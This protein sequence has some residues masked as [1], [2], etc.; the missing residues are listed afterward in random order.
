MRKGVRLINCAAR[1]HL[2]RSG[3][4]RRPEERPAW[5][6]WR[7]TSSRRA[8]HQQPAVRHAQRA[9]PRRTW[10]PAPKRPRR[11]WPSKASNLLVDYLTTGAIRHA[12]NMTPLDAKTLAELRGYLDVG[13][14]LG[15]LLAQFETALDQAAARCNYRGEVAGKNT[16]LITASF[17]AGLLASALEEDDQ[18]RQCR[19]A[20]ARAR[21]RAGRADAR[22]TWA[23]SARS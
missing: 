3:A 10:A 5:A 15:L 16:R 21:H 18:H 12:V 1:R 7:S 14:R 8:L 2:R 23:L 17:A 11:K 19:S 6:A 9:L 13:Y 20:A 22:P 4:G